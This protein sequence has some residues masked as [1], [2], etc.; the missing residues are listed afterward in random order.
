MTAL[1]VLLTIACAYDYRKRI[2]PNY[3][4]AILLMTGTGWRFGREGPVGIPIF[5]SELFCVI[6]LLYPFFKIGVIGAGDV[7]LLGAAAA[8]LPFGKIFLFLFVS[9]LISAVISFM[10]LWKEKMF[11]ERF[12]VLARYLSAVAQSGK[13]RLYPGKPGESCRAGI[14][15][16]GPA[17]I[18]IL[19]YMGGIY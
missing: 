4:I 8:F 17:L 14:C 13:W 9:L 1:C 6:C 16:S 12:S 19:F 7:K 15:L 11:G 2:I 18:S 5:L 10:K 3:L